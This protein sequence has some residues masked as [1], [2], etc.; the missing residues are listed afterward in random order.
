[1]GSSRPFVVDVA[2]AAATAA[3]AHFLFYTTAAA[4]M[5]RPVKHTRRRSL[6][7]ILQIP[8]I[9]T[10]DGSIKSTAGPS[11]PPAHVGSVPADIILEIA[12]YL[13][14]SDVL[15]FSLTVRIYST[16]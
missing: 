7:A 5:E 14:P 1:L 6:K 4:V 3:D 10:R 15:N 9:I 13:W 11:A 16:S 12:E 2:A 8:S